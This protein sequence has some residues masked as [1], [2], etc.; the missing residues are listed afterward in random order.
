MAHKTAYKFFYSITEPRFIRDHR[1]FFFIAVSSILH[2][3]T[4]T[5]L[6]IDFAK[7]A[8]LDIQERFEVSKISTQELN[9]IK[10]K[11]FDE[12]NIKKQVV[13]NE[14]VG[15]NETP[16]DSR[17]VGEHNQSYAKQTIAKEIGSF[18]R[19]GAGAT[20]G[21]KTKSAM[22]PLINS[23]KAKRIK[24]SDLSFSAVGEKNPTEMTEMDEKF[25]DQMMTK[26]KA[27]IVPQ[28]ISNGNKAE[29]GLAANNDFIEDVPLGDMTNLNTTEFKYY[30]FYNRIKIQIEQYWGSTL[31][32]KSKI[33]INSGRRIAS[34][35]N[36]ITALEIT[37]D[38]KGA[39]VKI[40]IKST[41]GIQEFDDAAVESFNRAGP[42]PNPPHDLLVNGEAT[43]EW[44][45]V[46]K[47]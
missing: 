5:Y 44:G 45:F 19:A 21:E 30:G 47:V 46:V 43:L 12:K 2:L 10:A 27:Q 29:S 25:V 40:K 15:S 1:I 6:N 23:S 39:I 7:R 38:Q 26:A 33:L 24:L 14:Q 35:D 28:G 3:F 32:D 11:A 4:M 31:R 36:K 13:S 9:Q 41:S 22:M 18:K 37:L 34:G 16:R 20:E 42:F 8:N 17:F